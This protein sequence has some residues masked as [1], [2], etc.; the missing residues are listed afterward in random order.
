L[1]RTSSGALLAL[2]WTNVVLH[3]TGLA[4]AWIGLRPGSTLIPLRE[5]MAYL[6][7][8][9]LAWKWGWGIWM[10]CAV[11][12]V[13]F[14]TALRSRL[15]GNPVTGKL[16]LI[17]TIVGMT[18]DLFCDVLQIRTL[19]VAAA[20]SSRAI[21]LAFEQ[22]VT[23][24]GLAVANGLYTLGILLMNLCLRDI[25]RTSTLLVGWVAIVSGSALAAAGLVPSALLLQAATGLTIGAYSLWTVLVARDLR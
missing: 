14:M 7:S 17:F 5:R 3:A 24:G 11:S 1:S 16:A 22:L 6:A 21:F 4:M 2:A 25:A 18:A 23:I 13:A 12:L 9:P 10:L 15:P 20:E 19:P 8:Q